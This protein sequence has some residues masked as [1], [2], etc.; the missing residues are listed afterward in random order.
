L[1]KIAD[2]SLHLKHRSKLAR[3]QR[4]ATSLQQGALSAVKYEMKV[5]AILEVVVCAKTSRLL[6]LDW[7]FNNISG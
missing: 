2:M 6:L 1:E 7:N 5:G 3:Q 4:G